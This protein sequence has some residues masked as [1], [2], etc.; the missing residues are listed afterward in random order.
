MHSI[1][2]LET[3]FRYKHNHWSLNSNSALEPVTW[4]M[5]M[6]APKPS[7][8]IINWVHQ[9]SRILLWES[10]VKINLLLDS[11][12]EPRAAFGSKM[13]CDWVRWAFVGRWTWKNKKK[14]RLNLTLIAT[15]RH[16]S[17]L[18]PITR[19]QNMRQSMQSN[20]ALETGFQ[21]KHNHRSL[22]KTPLSSP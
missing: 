3:E 8:Q 20:I 17:R 18:S 5:I 19:K 16:H 11:I 12:F 22:N 10:K 13:K 9:L 2:D 1:N 21:Y 14:N 6:L 15:G 7:F 4:S